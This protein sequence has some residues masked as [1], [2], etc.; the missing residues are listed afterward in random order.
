MDTQTATPPEQLLNLPHPL[1]ANGLVKP[2]RNVGVV[3]YNLPT[4]CLGAECSRRAYTPEAEDAECC[5]SQA[6][7][8]RRVDYGP[9]L[10]VWFALEFVVEEDPAPEGESQGDCVIGDFGGAVVWY[11]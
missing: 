5:V 1:N 11:L 8:E 7:Y 2:V 10:D 9:W 6:R 3:E 4:E